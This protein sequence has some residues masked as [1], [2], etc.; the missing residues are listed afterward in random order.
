MQ[1]GQQRTAPQQGGMS[2]AFSHGAPAHG[3]GHAWATNASS[4]SPDPGTLGGAAF[5]TPWGGWGSFQAPDS[6]LEPFK[7]VTMPAL[8]ADLPHSDA[9]GQPLQPPTY[10]SSND[11]SPLGGADF[12]QRGGG[13]SLPIPPSGAPGKPDH[14][15]AGHPDAAPPPR[16]DGTFSPPSMEQLRLSLGAVLPAIDGHDSEPAAARPSGAPS[17]GLAPSNR[18]TADITSGPHALAGQ[19]GLGNLG[20]LDDRLAHLRH[21]QGPLSGPDNVSTSSDSFSDNVLRF[22]G[23]AGAEFQPGRMGSNDSLWGAL[24]AA[25]AGGVD[26]VGGPASQRAAANLARNRSGSSLSSMASS[27]GAQQMSGWGEHPLGE[28]PS[29]TLFVR[30]IS[31]TVDEAAI[32]ELFGQFGE[33]RSVHL[34]SKHRGFVMVSYY[35]LRAARAAIKALQGH[36]L[37]RRR[38]DIHYSIPKENP[39]DKDWNHGTLVVFNLPAEVSNTAL[40]TIFSQFGEVK[41]VRETPNRRQH[42]FV[43]FYDSSHAEAALRALDR[44]ELRGQV[45]KIERS[46]PGGVRRQVAPGNGS[47][48]SG[49]RPGSRHMSVSDLMAVRDMAFAQQL[50]QAG[51]ARAS[52][53]SSLASQGLG[54]G[55]GAGDAAMAQAQMQANVQARMRQVAGGADLGGDPAG[56]FGRAGGPGGPV[57]PFGWDAGR[58]GPR[59]D[60]VALVQAAQAGLLTLPMLCHA[61]ESGSLAPQQADLIAALIPPHQLPQQVP[62]GV[63]RGGHGMGFGDVGALQ[64]LAHMQQMRDAAAAQ[65]G[66]QGLPQGLSPWGPLGFPGA[67]QHAAQQQHP[68][69]PPGA[70]LPGVPQLSALL[71]DSDPSA[72]RALLQALGPNASAMIS[73][74]HKDQ[75]AAAPQAGAPQ[76]DLAK[77][78]PSVLEQGDEPA[79]GEVLGGG[80]AG[81]PAQDGAPASAASGLP[82]GPSAEASAHSRQGPGGIFYDADAHGGPAAALGWAPASASNPAQVALAA[83]AHALSG[84]MQSEAMRRASTGR[85][86]IGQLDPGKVPAGLPSRRGGSIELPRVH[87]ESALEA[88]QAAAAAATAAARATRRTDEDRP[89]TTTDEQFA[90][91]LSKVQAGEDTRCTL[92]VKNIPNKYTQRMLLQ[93]LDEAVHGMYDFFYLPIDFKNGCNVGY[94]F[95]NMLST[96]GVAVLVQRFHGRRWERFNS[97]KVCCVAYARIQGKAALVAHFQNS[98]LLLHEDKRC[99]P[100]LFSAD[101]QP[102]TFPL[103]GR[104]PGRR[105]RR[106]SGESRRNSNES[107][108]SAPSAP[109]SARSSTDRP[110]SFDQ[111]NSARTS[112]ERSSHDRSGHG[113]GHAAADNATSPTPAAERAHLGLATVQEERPSE[114]VGADMSRSRGEDASRSRGERASGDAGS[115][116]ATA[117][118]S[119]LFGT[120]MSLSR[121]GRT[122]RS[123]RDSEG[124]APRP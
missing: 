63:G 75:Q 45:L 34:S 97:E 89:R 105:S 28:H 104:T 31:S 9:P 95:I 12:F 30:N 76:A 74:L 111:P 72:L 61:V 29:R 46:R 49:S 14:G 92:M 26:A 123:S 77:A 6:S 2:G 100:V 43:E 62:G 16:G 21:F 119:S 58:Q 87:K 106:G 94:A 78:G 20:P 107:R 82:G 11:T 18:T 24:N 118:Q 42:R 33:V 1:P 90:L 114:G 53:N 60:V 73:Q 32:C 99:R 79:A 96:E 91:D 86:S 117:M 57:P 10:T 17:A 85:R 69:P 36:M 71:S 48:D 113:H 15:R 38:L 70:G 3:M 47:A 110:R 39:T 56:V 41:E 93:T 101:G 109:A 54:R 44:T 80:Q 84:S 8:T 115:G 19:G 55:Q 122:S 66:Q 65:G 52:S 83:A 124:E 27:A 67:G 112:H 25:M 64:Q 120:E 88:A 51:M 116:L 68:Q 50:G 98:T 13:L 102:E 35:D 103:P 4:A 59:M 5:A 22:T 40:A 7:P 23:P 108:R 81:A 121:R 37:H